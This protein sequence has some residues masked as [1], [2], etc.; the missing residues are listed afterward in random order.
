MIYVLQNAGS[1]LH[2]A[3]HYFVVDL[4]GEGLSVIQLPVQLTCT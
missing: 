3:W 1:K 2:D 4:A